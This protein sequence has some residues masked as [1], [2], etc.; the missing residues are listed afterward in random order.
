MHHI[1]L[2]E[3]TSQVNDTC[4]GRSEMINYFCSNF[5]DINDCVVHKMGLADTIYI[6]SGLCERK[7]QNRKHTLLKMHF[8]VKKNLV[9]KSSSEQQ[10]NIFQV[11]KFLDISDNVY[12]KNVFLNV[13]FYLVTVT[14]KNMFQ[15]FTRI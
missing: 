3:A 7:S 8:F 14:N 13:S 12:S 5:Y 6:F 9:W 11:N 4:R 15:I 2:T 10:R 1:Y